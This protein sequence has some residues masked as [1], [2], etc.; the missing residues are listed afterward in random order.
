MYEYNYYNKV[1]I[2]R[3]IN[4][5]NNTEL[6]GLGSMRIT[7]PLTCVQEGRVRSGQRARLQS[8]ASWVRIHLRMDHVD[9]VQSDSASAH[10]LWKLVLVV[11]YPT[12]I[13]YA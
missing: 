2:Y 13:P 10:Q 1:N 3:Y 9:D 8:G 4:S 5:I 6:T 7:I 12:S 11:H